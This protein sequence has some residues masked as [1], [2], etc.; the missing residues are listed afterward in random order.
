MI[1]ALGEGGDG[2]GAFDILESNMFGKDNSATLDPA[3]FIDDN[4][5]RK[6]AH[7]GLHKRRVCL[8]EA[9]KSSGA[10]RYNLDVLKRFITGEE[11]IVRANFG[12][13]T[14]VSFKPMKKQGSSNYDDVGAITSVAKMTAVPAGAGASS[15]GT[16]ASK[17]KSP[18]ESLG[19][20]FLSSG[21]GLATLVNDEKDVCHEEGRFLKIA[22]DVLEGVL[23][24]PAGSHV[25]FRE[26][27]QPTWD[28]LG[29]T[30]DIVAV[31]EPDSLDEHMQ[32]A[33][34]WYVDKLCGLSVP[35]RPA[36]V[37]EPGP[38]N[39]RGQ[40]V[41][42]ADWNLLRRCYQ[43]L[44]RDETS[45]THGEQQK[46]AKGRGRKVGDWRYQDC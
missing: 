4:E 39:D 37:S 26:V 38:G 5:W 41:D 9:K 31:L 46:L 16:R 32:S 42:D 8:K 44:W 34:S 21:V 20:R 2:K 23:S 30:S 43:I 27:L 24:S 40:S 1:I 12:F 17:K 36:C 11:L 3:I 6:S 13:S 18:T 25:Y 10:T 28:E 22:A 19:R 29:T 15:S 45:K 7:F 33:S 14:E 35:Q